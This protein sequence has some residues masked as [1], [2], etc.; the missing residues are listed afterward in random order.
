MKKTI[1]PL[2]LLISILTVACG[3]LG[4]SGPGVLTLK[5]P[6]ADKQE[7][8]VKSGGFYVSTKTWSAKGKMSTSSSHFICV[9]D[10]EIDLSQGSISINKKVADRETKV[11]FDI[12]GE[13]NS[14][15]KSL[16]K[17]TTYPIGK[18]GES[19]AFS[20]ID[21]VSIRTFKD[22]KEV[23]HEFNNHKTTGDIKISSASA[24]TI[25]GEINLTDGE[26][27]IKGTFT[28]K[29]YKKL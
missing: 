12:D 21:S 19:F 23:R 25:S 27:E 3:G 13:E 18:M 5:F 6:G 28:A 1:L 16:L 4:S 17:T 20:S 29:A 14:D 8:P 9:A 11:C 7:M 22:G 24:D 26:R 15:D 10:Y 2:F